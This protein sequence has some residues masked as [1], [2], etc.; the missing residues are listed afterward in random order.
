[1]VVKFKLSLQQKTLDG[2]QNFTDFLMLRSTKSLLD[3]TNE[4]PANT[5]VKYG[6]AKHNDKSPKLLIDQERQ[7]MPKYLEMRRFDPAALYS[8]GCCGNS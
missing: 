8:R 7:L 4:V 5:E 2:A 1:M 3:K 6:Y